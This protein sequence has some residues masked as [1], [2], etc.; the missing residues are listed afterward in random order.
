MKPIVTVPLYHD[1][2]DKRV[3]K[4][5]N[6]NLATHELNMGLVDSY[7]PPQTGNGTIRAFMVD[8]VAFSLFLAALVVWTLFMYGV[9]G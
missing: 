2:N 3:I 8:A 6:R 5:I 7:E 9:A 1:T 4:Y